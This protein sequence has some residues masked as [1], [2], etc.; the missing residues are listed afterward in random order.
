MYDQML[1][2]FRKAAESTMQLQQEALRSW[3]R[4]WGEMPTMP[5]VPVS[6]SAGPALAA[7]WL[8]QIRAFQKTWAGY[9]SETLT[10]HRK[11]LDAQYEAGIKTIEEAFR[12]AEAR[13][14]EHFRRLM[15]ELWRQGFETLKTMSESQMRDV[16]AISEKWME[17]MTKGM[18]Q[19]TKV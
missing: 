14:P 16:Q 8:D 17:V 6:T 11:S 10:R 12:V 5:G 7:T 3:T 15:E 13:D 19:A 2:T 4:Q 18:Q 9:M 1:E